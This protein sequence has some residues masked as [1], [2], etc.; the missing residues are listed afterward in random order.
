MSTGSRKIDRLV[1][2][3]RDRGLEVEVTVDDNHGHRSVAVVIQLPR[4]E[5]PTNMLQV[6]QNADRIFAHWMWQREPGRTPK[7]ASA[8][9]TT[10]T[11][12]NDIQAKVLP[13]AIGIMADDLD[14]RT[15]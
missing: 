13:Y 14:R 7:L 10:Y 2:G 3:A 15:S 11:I 1:N 5:N 9:R 4:I 8:Q 12:T 6:V